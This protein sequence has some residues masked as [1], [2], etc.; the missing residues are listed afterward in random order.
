MNTNLISVIIALLII[1]ATFYR[2]LDRELLKS[3]LFTVFFIIALWINMPCFV[4]ISEPANVNNYLFLLPFKLYSAG[5]I[6]YAILAN[7][8]LCLI[9]FLYDKFSNRTT[10]SLSK[11]KK[12]YD[13]FG[14]D[15]IELYVIDK[16]LDFLDKKKFKKQAER[17]QHLGKNCKILCES[18]TNKDLLDLYK[19]AREYGVKIRFY[20][21]SDYMTN[22]KGQIKIDQGGNKKAIF[23]SRVNNIFT[24]SELNNQFL[25]SSI[26][27]RYK[28]V[29]S[30][31]SE[32]ETLVDLQSG[33]DGNEELGDRGIMK[34]IKLFLLTMLPYI[35][36]G[37]IL[38]ALAS[39]LAI[40]VLIM[41][42]AHFIKDITL[43][44]KS[45]DIVPEPKVIFEDEVV[46]D[47][48][49]IFED[50]VLD[51]EALENDNG[52]M[53]NVLMEAQEGSED[54]GILG[55]DKVS[56]KEIRT[57]T[58]LDSLDEMPED[59]WD[60]SMKQNRKAMAWV[61]A[62]DE[63]Y[64]LYIGG[65]GG[66]AANENSSCLFYSYNNVEQIRI[67]GNF[68][69]E[70][71]KMM[72]RMF[73]YCVNLTELDINWFNTSKA[74]NMFSMFYG[75]ENVRELD[76][77]GFDTSNVT[78]M[79][80]MFENC[81]N[82]SKLD[83]SKFNTSKVTNMSYMFYGCANLSKLDVKEFDTSNVTNM[84]S[85]FSGCTYLN[86][87][88]VSKFDTS[89]VTDMSY[90]FCDC[91]NLSK[92][93]TSM[94]ITSKVEN[95]YCM[96]LGCT[97]LSELDVNG[98]DTSKVKD[99]SYMFYGCTNL[100]KLDVGLFDTSNVT[101]MSCM[102]YGCTYLNK[103]YVNEFNTSKVTDMSYMFYGCTDLSKLDVS[104][105]DTSNVTDM[106]CMFAECDSINF[107]D[108]TNFNTSNVRDAENMF[109]DCNNL[110]YP[111]ISNFEPRLIDNLGLPEII[112][113]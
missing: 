101:D 87:L 67:N 15:A 6:F 105:F 54:D 34:R 79:Y 85:M 95:M 9:L 47:P 46:P 98:F 45:E 30:K 75:C 43:E 112:N 88:D 96:F 35:D 10:Y 49:V 93:N 100:S 40:I 25:V 108:V 80:A 68:H 89:K 26:L 109:S 21:E 37:K 97:Y 73:C 50:E 110:E 13:T 1:F 4:N 62:R 86:E 36:F 42:T 91:S 39:I 90:M 81:R 104:K 18:T 53:D 113:N 64:D 38:I 63:G 41:A 71:A 44:T 28:E 23:T 20:S 69:T 31:A 74:K 2:I 107:L 83:V 99:M 16:D 77:S 56:R 5:N 111:D 60:V 59:A 14:I 84:R 106:S 19:E 12:E 78:D 61:I 51:D 11:I 24:K 103:L 66:V 72:Q 102:F 92:L 82:L 76:V 29:F 55:Y 70:N 7:I 27:E 17:I 33:H 48:K 65:K 94:F 22:L 52:W 58:F 8:I 57:I 3:I 32:P